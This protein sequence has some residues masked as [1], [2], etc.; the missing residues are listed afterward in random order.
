M[1]AVL[2]GGDS[3]LAAFEKSTGDLKWKVDRNYE[4]PVENDHSY[5]TPNVI[6]GPD[7][8]ERILVWGAE[9]LTAHSAEDGEIIWSS[10]GF[11]PEEKSN[12]VAVSSAL[13]ADGVA[14]VP[15]GRG[16]FLAGVKLG[17]DGDVTRSHRLWT[18]DDTGAFVPTPAVANGQVLVLRDKGEIEAIDPKNGKTTWSGAL[19]RESDKYYASPSVGGD[20]IYA[21]RE[22]GVVFV[23]AREGDGLKVL[24]ENDFME[25]IIASPVP[26]AD[27]VL[28]RSEKTPLQLR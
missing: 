15:Y 21:A 20:K 28:I 26:V 22:D 23:A 8:K 13:V 25:R 6:V 2:H 11:N 12:W 19:P 27:R 24:S 9:R 14:I 1:V 18:R 16:A 17:G 7:G 10:E 4:T 5:A 3:F